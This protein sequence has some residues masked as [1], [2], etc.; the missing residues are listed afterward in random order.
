MYAVEFT[1]SIKD[2]V[3]EVPEAYR[4][5]FKGHVKVILLASE[6]I[7]DD[8][9]IIRDLLAQPLVIPDFTPLSRG[10]AHAR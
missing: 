8:D 5:R 10:D 7:K 2:G 3:I 6:E 1:T 9:D 4:Q